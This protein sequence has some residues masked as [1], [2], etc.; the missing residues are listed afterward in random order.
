MTLE[1][2]NYIDGQWRTGAATIENRNPSDVSDLIGFYEQADAGQVEQ[3]I[4]A[5]SA[6]PPAWAAAG[7]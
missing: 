2:R 3:A 5:A 7:P 4:A 1:T 6:A